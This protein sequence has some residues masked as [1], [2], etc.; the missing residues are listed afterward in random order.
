AELVRSRT[1]GNAL[2]VTELLR[3][4]RAD[5]QAQ[6]LRANLAGNV[7]HRVAEL[8]A[9]RLGRLP[10]PVAQLVTA[11]AVLGASGDVRHL[12]A[13]RR[14]PLD[15][16]ADLIGQARAARLLEAA[17]ATRWQFRHELV[18]DAVYGTAT[19]RARAQL[20][21]RALDV[22]AADPATPPGVLAHH[23]LAAQPLL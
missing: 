19:G 9:H 4:A 18:R 1:D 6:E 10:E 13:I 3:T 21:Q 15:A 23:A 8:I 11:A 5:V 12:A 2:F 7:P 20:H 14:L 22:L 16:T 17:A